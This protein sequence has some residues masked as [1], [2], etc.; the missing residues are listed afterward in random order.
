MVRD[1]TATKEMQQYLMPK[2]V[3]AGKLKGNPKIRMANVPLRTIGEGMDTPT[4]RIAE[5]AEYELRDFVGS[6]P[7]TL[8]IR[9]TS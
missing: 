4:E 6:T 1:G 5:L 7:V 2:Y 3:Q 9:Q 8:E